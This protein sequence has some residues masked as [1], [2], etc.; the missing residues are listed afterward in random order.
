MQHVKEP[1][2]NLA[3]PTVVFRLLEVH[4]LGHLCQIFFRGSTH[5]PAVLCGHRCYLLADALLA[6]GIHVVKEGVKVVAEEFAQ[7]VVSH[8][9]MQQALHHVIHVAV[10]AEDDIY[11]IAGRTVQS[12]VALLL[13]GQLL[14]GNLVGSCH[15][16]YSVAYV[17]TLGCLHHLLLETVLGSLQHVVVT[18]LA[19]ATQFAHLHSV[20]VDL[21]VDLDAGHVVEVPEPGLHGGELVLVSVGLGD[22]RR[23][24][25]DGGLALGEDVSVLVPLPSDVDLDVLAVGALGVELDD[26]SLGVIGG[27]PDVIDDPLHPAVEVLGDDLVGTC[28]VRIVD[29][30]EEVVEGLDVVVDDVFVLEV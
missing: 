27:N 25:P 16:L 12:L 26:T 2:L 23:V 22:L 7:S 15:Y 5:I 19:V 29:G 13:L 18:F 28:L 1:G 11:L 30:G 10:I 24:D 3:P 9:L 4:S 6:T 8:A 20:L 14:V 21:E 17:H